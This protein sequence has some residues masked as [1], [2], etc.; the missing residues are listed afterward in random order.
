M[1]TAILYRWF[2]K[3]ANKMYFFS[4]LITLILWNILLAILTKK[5][6][7]ENSQTIKILDLENGYT[8]AQ[9][10]EWW[11]NYLPDGLWWY[12]FINCF[13]DVLYPITY[14]LFAIFTLV[15]LLEYSVPKLVNNLYKLC[16]L[17]VVVFVADMIENVS[18]FVALRK[19]PAPSNT[20][21]EIAS[22]FTQI[23][24]LFL[25]IVL[26]LIIIG[27]ATYF[28]NGKEAKNHLNNYNIL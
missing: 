1:K 5:I 2:A 25:I 26:T 24:W 16:F 11:N 21:L 12:S 28:A 20:V 6:I 9:V 22:V 4:T 3:R 13:V 27:I 15:I 19:F 14:T 7:P 18:V 8:P 10:Y 17:P 23:K